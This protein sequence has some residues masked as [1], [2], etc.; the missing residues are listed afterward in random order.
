MVE[1]FIICKIKLRRS[2][3][4]SQLNSQ[5]PLDNHKEVNTMLL[6]LNGL[7]FLIFLIFFI[8]LIAVQ[9]LIII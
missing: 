7:L 5:E 3:P 1:F 9:L 6:W 2:L 8:I 4:F